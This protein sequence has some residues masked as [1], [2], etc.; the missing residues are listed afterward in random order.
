MNR[1]SS[2]FV[3][4]AFTLALFP[5]MAGAA[6]ESDPF[7]TDL[8][9]GQHTDVGDIKIWNDADFVYIQYETVQP[10]CLMETHLQ[11][12]PQLSD[13]PQANGNPI[14]GQFDYKT[15]HDCVTT[16]LYT[17]PLS[18]SSCGLYIAAH[19]VINTGETAWGS[20]PAFPG[21]NWATYITYQAK[22]CHRTPTA[23]DTHVK[24]TK[25][26]TATPTG[27]HIKHTKT[28]TATPTGTHIKRTKTPTATPTGTHIK[29]TKTPTAT[30][31]PSATSTNTPTHT[32]TAT[33]TNTATNT[34]TSTPTH[35][36]TFT[37]TSTFTPTPTPSVCVPEVITAD[38]SKVANAGDSVEG[39]D[40]VAPG[41]NINAKGT[42][43][44]IMEGEDP[45]VFGSPNKGTIKNGGV[46]PGGGF[47]DR[48]T[49]DAK[50]AHLYSFT[51]AKPISAFTLHML[52]YGD[53]N[54][55]KVK[56]HTAVMIAYNAS[57]EVTRERLHF[58]TDPPVL[59]PHSSDKYGDLYFTG[60]AL[61][62]APGEPGNWT[63]NIYGSGIERVVLQFPE[64][65]DPNIGFDRLT[66]VTECPVCQPLSVTGNFSHPQFPTGSSVEGPGAVAPFLE[67]DAKGTAIQ[68]LPNEKPFIFGAP[69]DATITNGNLAPQGGFSDQDTRD[70]KQAHLYTFAF[71]GLPPGTS[72]GSFSLHMLDFGDL[73]T[74]RSTS[75]F[76]S[77]TAYNASG[78]ILSQRGLSYTTP[79]DFNPRSSDKYGDL[80]FSGD[81]V[82]AALQE[83]GNW[84][85]DVSG[86]E[87]ARVVLRFGAGFDPNIGFDQLK[88]NLVCT[89]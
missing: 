43:V 70:A 83:P 87:V 18:G 58:E 64:G 74:A 59:N 61:G 13:I 76:V 39:M 42:A 4:L 69:N 50:Q 66:F 48:D 19:A 25:T 54:W 84:I 46:A 78:G 14:P 88:F 40:K 79:P 6:T 26:P 82:T 49:R 5:A 75:H 85:W 55:E 36:P 20:G 62:A 81:A 47:S 44:K 53:L 28:P 32:A 68:I 8:I 10:Y 24:H 7:I 31:T 80:Y 21:K 89:P 35:T 86:T 77:M 41:L 33:G 65:Y 17:V 9:A 16:F 72:I 23:T 57:G 15:K 34:P 67:I 38:F 12:A 11:V 30:R 73:N 37:P 45:F 2:L 60:D 22:G 52:D 71:A 51:F 3:I 63:W 56:P 1:I 27:T 29:H